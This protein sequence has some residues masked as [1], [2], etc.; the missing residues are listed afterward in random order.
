M[1]AIRR[2]LG[3][4]YGIRQTFP[5]YD[6]CG[7]VVRRDDRTMVSPVKIDRRGTQ[8]RILVQFKCPHQFIGNGAPE[9][10]DGP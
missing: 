3:C 10:A 8:Y 2:R 7:Y 9:P 6:S 5:A 1:T 4:R